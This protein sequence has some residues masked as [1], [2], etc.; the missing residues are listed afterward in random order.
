MTQSQRLDERCIQY[1]NEEPNEIVKTNV[2]LF[3]LFSNMQQLRKTFFTMFPKWKP[4]NQ[5][6]RVA[7]KDFAFTPLV[8]VAFNDIFQFGYLPVSHFVD[9]LDKNSMKIL[10]D[11]ISRK[12]VWAAMYPMVDKSYKLTVVSIF[13]DEDGNLGSIVQFEM[14]QYGL[15]FKLNL[16][17]LNDALRL[18]PGIENQNTIKAHFEKIRDELKLEVKSQSCRTNDE[19]QKEWII[20]QMLKENPQCSNYEILEKLQKFGM[21]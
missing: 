5:T 4:A 16:N 14:L 17:S 20:E 7:V 3:S 1:L 18:I 15:C 10:Q 6:L 13:H 12:L 2:A 19:Q 11:L 9:V 21:I 8:D